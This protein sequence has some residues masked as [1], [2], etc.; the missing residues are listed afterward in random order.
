MLGAL[1]EGKSSIDGFLAGE[2][3]L[4]TIAC[5]T[6]MGAVIT[7]CGNKVTVSGNGLHGLTKPEKTLDVG[8]SGTSL[9]L[10]TGILAGQSFVSRVTGDASIQRR[11]MDRVIAPLTLMGAKFSGNLAPSKLAAERSKESNTRFL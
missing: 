3:C 9:R 4:S 2:D 10:M 8:N 6:S 11:P 7:R 5:F 1:A